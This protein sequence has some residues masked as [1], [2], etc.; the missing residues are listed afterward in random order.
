MI[1]K[2][3]LLNEVVRF[4]LPVTIFLFHEL[5]DCDVSVWFSYT[6][7]AKQSLVADASMGSSN[8]NSNT[9]DKYKQIS[10]GTNS[11]QQA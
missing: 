2:Q 11:H 10:A 8:S 4:P 5:L 3:V 9:C 1:N 7:D 6:P